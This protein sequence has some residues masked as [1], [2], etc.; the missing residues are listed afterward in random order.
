G[1]AV[2]ASEIDGATTFTGNENV[3]LG[4]G[5]GII[6]CEDGNYFGD[7]VTVSDNTGAVD[8]SGNIIRGDLTGEGNDPAPTGS[9]NRVRGEAGRPRRP[10]PHRP[11]P[12]TRRRSPTTGARSAGPALRHPLSWRAPP[13]WADLPLTPGCVGPG[14]VR[15]PGPGRTLEP[16]GPW[17]RG[18]AG[19]LDLAVGRACGASSAK[20]TLED[21]EEISVPE[22]ERPVECEHR[23]VAEVR[24]GLDP[25]GSGCERF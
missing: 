21:R 24:V 11:P 22:A 18:R 17:S 5:A 3:Q 16:C 13:T 12:P 2:C 6:D 23:R 19:A 10:G 9:D 20:R 25:A 7:D 8:V 1:T 15:E 14:R 4:T